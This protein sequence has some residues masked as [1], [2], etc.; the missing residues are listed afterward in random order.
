MTTRPTLS[1]YQHRV[2]WLLSQGN[3]PT[4]V[5]QIIEADRQS[6]TSA[7]VLVRAKLN[8]RTNTQAVLLCYRLG[9]IGLY[10]TCGTR[11]SYLR[12]MDRD[13]PACPACK[14]ANN[15]WVMC[16]PKVDAQAA[17]PE[18][19]DE[20]HVRLLKA[21]HCGRTKEEIMLSW[22]VGRSRLT[23][24]ITEMYRRLGVS[25]L[26][27][28]VRRD[29]AVKAGQKQGYLGQVAPKPPPLPPRSGSGRLTD[30]EVHT[31]AALRDC[32]LRQASVRLEIPRSAVSSRLHCIYVKLGVNHLPRDD[33]RE[34]AIKAARNQG[35]AL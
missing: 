2:M 18:P 35:Y 30:L 19:L 12:H 20:V 4:E 29:A 16:G 23:R 8:A 25:H 11:S 24:H 33:K 27:R 1:R 6:V 7:C 5:A 28:D 3:T 9:L 34:A 10:E 22:G 14:H 15:E 26:P 31:L 13:E 21:L 17:D 32:S